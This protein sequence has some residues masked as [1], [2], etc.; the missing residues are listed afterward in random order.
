MLENSSLYLR[1]VAKFPDGTEALMTASTTAQLREK[2][3]DRLA[4]E[5]Y[6]LLHKATRPF[7]FAQCWCAH[8]TELVPMWER[9]SPSERPNV[10]SKHGIAIR[11][12]FAALRNSLDKKDERLVRMS[13]IKYLD[14]HSELSNYDN[15]LSAFLEKDISLID[16]RELRVLFYD[17]EAFQKSTQIP[18][19]RDPQ[20][21]R[22][23]INPITLVESVIPSP[24]A[25][26]T[27][28][29]QI[30][31]LLSNFGIENRLEHSRLREKASY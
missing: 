30:R 25:G 15:M 4:I 13:L 31:S 6:F 27:E 16:E 23:P 1:S 9:F 29:D 3:P 2:E 19:Y 17:I 7:G 28:I 8:S 26:S 12:S 18:T 11:T 5:K 10:I 20:Y 21:R 24:T 14:R 22:I